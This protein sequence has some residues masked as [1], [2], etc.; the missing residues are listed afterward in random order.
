[1]SL[2]F[3]LG[4]KKASFCVRD[5]CSVR[6]FLHFDVYNKNWHLK[7]IRTMQSVCV[8]MQE[9]GERRTPTIIITGAHLPF[10][11]WYFAFDYVLSTKNL[12]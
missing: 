10:S 4:M 11:G 7:S 5:A 3:S 8:W 6:G 1:M 2:L 12:I 9:N